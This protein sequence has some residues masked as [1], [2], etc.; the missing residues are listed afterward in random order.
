MEKP[1]E[2]RN[3]QPSKSQRK[4]DMAQLQA[5]G[6]ELVDLPLST[7]E[8]LALPE[9]IRD[10]I[11]EAKGISKHGARNRQI[12]YLGRLLCTVD[13]HA[14]R[15]RLDAMT[16]GHRHAVDQFHAVE[17]W[18]DRLIAEGDG[19]LDALLQ[20][21]PHANIQHI[22]QLLRNVRKQ[23]AANKPPEARRTLF[24]YLRELME[25]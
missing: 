25:P 19:A 22:R 9:P 24:K 14:I 4:R 18:R 15:A 1:P 20:E 8:A 16:R 5:L 13:A 2:E 10:A 3:E 11:A 12:K 21:L 7:L 17:Q 23:A 6:A